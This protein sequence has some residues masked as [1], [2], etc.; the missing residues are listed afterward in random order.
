MKRK[1]INVLP[2]TNCPYE[3]DRRVKRN[4]KAE[5][6]TFLQDLL[7]GLIVSGMFVSMLIMWCMG[8]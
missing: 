5:G 3:E 7:F 2:W 8:F 4:K 6:P 1:E